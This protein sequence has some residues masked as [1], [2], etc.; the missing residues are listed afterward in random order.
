MVV[1]HHDSEAVLPEQLLNGLQSALSVRHLQHHL[2]CQGAVTALS[3]SGGAWE[4]K[5]ALH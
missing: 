4:V 2:A 5:Q 1:F 3:V